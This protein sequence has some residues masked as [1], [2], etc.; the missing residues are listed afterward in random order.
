MD[1]LS[2][3]CPYCRGVHLGR[4]RHGAQADGPKRIRCGMVMVV[5]RRTY[6]RTEAA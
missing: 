1:W 6:R 3:R 2:I 4:V 5:V